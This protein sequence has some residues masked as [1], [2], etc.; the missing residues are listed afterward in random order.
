MNATN[1]TLTFVAVAAVTALAAIGVRFANRPPVV[2]G[3]SDVGQEFYPD[4]TDPLKATELSVVK[5]DPDLKEARSFSVKRRED[6]LWVIPSH[7]DYPAEA[8]E[9]LAKTAAS[10][11]GI[12][13]VALQSRSKDDWARYGVEDPT[14]TAVGSVEGSDEKDQV[15]GTRITLKDA[16]T[17]SLVD[18]I[19]G[20]AVEG[21]E[22]HYYVRQPEKNP[23]FIAKMDA[24]LSAKF[25]DWIE[26]DLLKVTQAD[27]VK[28]IVDRYSVD[29]AQGAILQ[30]ETLVLDKDATTSKWVLEGLNTETESLKDIPIT[31]VTRNLDQLKI[32]GV[33]PKPQGLNADLTVSREVAGNPLLRQ[34]LQAD[35]QRQ[36]FYIARGQNDQVKLVSNE[37][38]LI[39]GTNNGVKYTLYFGEIARGSEKDIETGLNESKGD[40]AA[41]EAGSAD[42]DSKKGEDGKSETSPAAT[43]D[44][45]ESGPRRYLL[46]KVEYD[47]SL[48]GPKPV[49][50]TAPEKPAI[51]NDAAPAGEKPA[52]APT[53]D[54]DKAAPDADAAPADPSAPKT[55]APKTEAPETEAPKT[56]APASDAPTNESKP[57]EPKTEETKPQAPVTD[58]AS[59]SEPKTDEGTECGQDAETGAAE[60]ADPPAEDTAPTE[61]AVAQDNPATPPA[62]PQAPAADEKPAAPADEKPATEQPAQPA[63]PAQESPTPA[64]EGTPAQPQADPK[65]EAQKAFDKAMGEYQSAKAA[66]ESSLKTWEDRAKSGRKKADELAERFGSWYYVITAESFEKFKI[67]RDAVVGPKEAETPAVEGT[68]PA[69]P[70]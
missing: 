26:P 54:A 58:E 63:A 2:E 64:A 52:D 60:K 70:N 62:E 50:P 44:E 6:G 20:K 68:P 33:R 17:N 45:P 3:F 42:D 30:G 15:R 8:R 25:S 55:E 24:D 65:A 22:K 16:S 34:V 4:F 39:A 69:T 61:P 56:D 51:L 46:V 38:E 37:G 53:A 10:L 7:H 57:E 5:Y 1:R 19:V 43:P 12:R 32:V 21:R 66:Y 28:L 36:G 41:E 67:S 47:E 29:E 49:E 35:M 11:I 9:R 23:V 31:D 14:A 59:A 13:K 48:L 27:I 40:A 18:V